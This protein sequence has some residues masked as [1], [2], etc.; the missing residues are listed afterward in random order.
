MYDYICQTP[1]LKDV[2]DIGSWL[3]FLTEELDDSRHFAELGGSAMALGV[4]SQSQGHG[5]LEE[6][7]SMFNELVTCSRNSSSEEVWLPKTKDH[8]GTTCLHAACRSG[9]GS[10]IE[11]LVLLDEGAEKAEARNARNREVSPPESF[12]HDV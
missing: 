5:H 4:G 6:K 8:N 3:S 9:S 12:E 11:V 10:I 2:Q 1:A 7:S